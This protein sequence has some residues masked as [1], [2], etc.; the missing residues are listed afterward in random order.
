MVLAEVGVAVRVGD[1]ADDAVA[2]DHEQESV[3]NEVVHDGGVRDLRLIEPFELR[4]NK[5]EDRKDGAVENDDQK[6]EKPKQIQFIV[7]STA[8]ANSLFQK[9]YFVQQLAPPNSCDVLK[10]NFIGLPCLF[11]ASV[12]LFCN[13]G[14][15]SSVLGC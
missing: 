9:T 8:G 10:L 4:P 2:S 3:E 11:M 5:I 12:S 7:N 1:R 13:T 6:D 14:V 15:C